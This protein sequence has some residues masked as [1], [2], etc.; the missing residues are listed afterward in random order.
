[1]F[2]TVANPTSTLGAMSATCLINANL[3]VPKRTKK[4]RKLEHETDV[5]STGEGGTVAEGIIRLARSRFSSQV[6]LF[7][8]CICSVALYM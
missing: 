2:T 3:R 6:L 1:L 5:Y 7:I 8:F 4:K